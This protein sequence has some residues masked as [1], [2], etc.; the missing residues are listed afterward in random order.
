MRSCQVIEW[1]GPAHPL[2][3][4]WMWVRRMDTLVMWP[5]GAAPSLGLGDQGRGREGEPYL[6]G[7]ASRWRE[8]VWHEEGEQGGDEEHC[9]QGMFAH[10]IVERWNP[11]G[12]GAPAFFLVWV[13]EV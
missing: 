11:T 2:S 12:L 10:P 9:Q 4:L 3:P 8:A 6:P 1:A 5:R 13:F 7:M